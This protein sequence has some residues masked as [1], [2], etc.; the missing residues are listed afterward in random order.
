MLLTDVISRSLHSRDVSKVPS[1]TSS[2]QVKENTRKRTAK[3]FATP[4]LTSDRPDNFY[5][6]NWRVLGGG[7]RMSNGESYCDL[8][9]F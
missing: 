7:V 2:A 6:I 1:S 3:R 8:T 9:W 5:R 4:K